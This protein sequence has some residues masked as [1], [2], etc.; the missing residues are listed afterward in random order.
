MN[1]DDNRDWVREG[2]QCAAMR[3]PPCHFCENAT[4]EE[5]EAFIG[6]K[7]GGP[8]AMAIEPV[9]TV[10]PVPTPDTPPPHPSV[11]I[12]EE[13]AARGWTVDELSQQMPGFRFHNFLTI[14]VYLAVGPTSTNCRLGDETVERL[15]HAFGGD[16]ALFV[17]LERAWLESIGITSCPMI[18]AFDAWLDDR[19]RAPRLP[20]EQ[21][22]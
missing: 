17:N 20:G 4:E 21:P 11:Y 13:M 9:A 8:S 22:T 7:R 14:A 2:C 5:I 18:E 16:P 12:R 6:V 19:G 3:H 15:A 1:D 10:E